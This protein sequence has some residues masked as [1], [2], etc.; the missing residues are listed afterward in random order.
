MYIDKITPNNQMCTFFKSL[1]I[2]L[3]SFCGS[4]VQEDNNE[5]NKE[6]DKEIDQPMLVRPSQSSSVPQ[7]INKN[8]FPK[9]RNIINKE[10]ITNKDRDWDI[11]H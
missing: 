5:D 9:Q 7:Y 2:Y 10:N 1:Y 4:H 3:T 6:Y 11:L 8:D